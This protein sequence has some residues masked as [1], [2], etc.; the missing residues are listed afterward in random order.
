MA[1]PKLPVDAPLGEQPK[2]PLSPARILALLDAIT[3]GGKS[4]GLPVP[5]PIKTARDTSCDSSSD[6]SRV[7]LRRVRPSAPSIRTE[8]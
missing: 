5:Q 4:S 8:G 2:V 3:V 1:K 7:T 6:G